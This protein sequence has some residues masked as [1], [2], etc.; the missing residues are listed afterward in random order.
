MSSN[1][2]LRRRPPASRRERCRA[3][4]EADPSS[5][6]APGCFWAMMEASAAVISAYQE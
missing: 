4:A 1:A 6:A 2:F 3:A 5:P